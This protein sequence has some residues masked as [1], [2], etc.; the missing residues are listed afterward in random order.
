[1]VADR[2]RLIDGFLTVEGG[3]D[4][5]FPPSLINANQLAWAVNTTVR[6][7][8]PTA[9][10]GWKRR[11]L[12]FT[13]PT[14]TLFE[15]GLFQGAGSYVAD[16]GRA[17]LVASISG[18]IFTIDI[19]SFTVNDIT[20]AGDANMANQPKAWF[21]QAERWLVVQNGLNRPF[22][23]DGA[24]S[25]RTLQ[26]EVPIGGPMA[27]GKGRLWV[28]R[29]SEYFGGDLVWSDQTL[30]RDSVIRFTENTFLNE[31]GAFAVPAGP[32]TGLAF[33]ANLDTSLGDGDLLVFTSQA[34]HAFSAPIDRT[35]WK[36]LEYPIQRYA[37]LNYGALNHESIAVLNGDVLFRAQ[38]GIR[39]L[40]YA[41]RDFTEWGNTPISRQA[42]RALEYDTKA[43]LPFCSSVNFDN[44]LLM[45][46][47]PQRINGHGT[48][49]KGLVALDYSLVSGMGQKYPPA[50]EGVWTGLRILQVVTV[51]VS[52]ED[53]A[54][55]FA[56]SNTNTIELWEITRDA[57]FDHDGSDD[58]PIEW[59]FETRSTPFAQPMGKKRLMGAEQWYD[60]VA[61][62]VSITARFRADL[63]ECWTEWG[64]ITDCAKYRDCDPVDPYECHAVRY[65]QKARRSR[66]AFPMPPDVVDPQTGGFT[67]DGFEFQVRYEITGRLRMKRLM[68]VASS[69][70][71]DIAGDISL[72]GC[73]TV[74]NVGCQ[75]E[76]LALECPGICQPADY[77]YSIEGPPPVCDAPVITEPPVGVTVD[78]GQ[79]IELSVV[80]TGTAPLEYQWYKDGNP[81]YAATLDTLTIDPS[82]LADAGSYYVVVTNA[83]GEAQSYPAEVIVNPVCDYDL[84]IDVEPASTD[85]SN[86]IGWV[87]VNSL[88]T[89]NGVTDLV[90]GAS[91]T[92]ETSYAFAFNTGLERVSIP[93]ATA[94]LPGPL[95]S[96]L[97]F[98]QM[99][100]LLEIDVPIVTFTALLRIRD[101]PLLASISLPALTGGYHYAWAGMGQSPVVTLF[102]IRDN[103]SLTTIDLGSFVPDSFGPNREHQA[104]FSGNALTAASVN[105]ILAR[106]AANPAWGSV[107]PSPVL[108][109]S[110]G[111]N[112]APTGQGLIDKADLISRGA[113]VTTN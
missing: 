13:Y 7:G 34:S 49:H 81:V 57:L 62:N 108:D 83:C 36:D 103:P 99:V 32:I 19:P 63:S 55:I 72:A 4:S 45:T 2:N 54:F 35:V 52:G 80:A 71:E 8:W 92:I 101:N 27:Y 59:I 73:A 37:L 39:S 16:N 111:T 28:A 17:F 60:H 91:G 90:L 25:R 75:T 93:N 97:S 89:T 85:F 41:R 95:G 98:Q 107:S 38:D 30:G 70:P 22:L 21:C 18:R 15:D 43:L 29:D 6:G 23:W 65:Y 26:N 44:R 79:P 77:G 5:G 88:E 84:L 33:A 58:V 51:R 46:V 9:R 48:I 104:V 40:A 56:L 69:V 94:M 42:R 110:G 106:F 47:S 74:P 61:G 105:H 24:G 113:T 14:Q 109:L 20:I 31:G 87:S 11:Q 112:A 100:S 53:R 12:T 96:S 76:C 67:R 86:K 1:M 50:W 10:P 78:E 64:T 102:T 68:L 3:V 82:T 66:I